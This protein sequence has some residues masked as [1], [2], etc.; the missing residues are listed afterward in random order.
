MMCR[1]NNNILPA[2]LMTFTMSTTGFD[3]CP[4]IDRWY[5]Q[6]IKQLSFGLT[7]VTLEQ[8]IKS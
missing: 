5:M 8:S 7:M 2:M 6:F 1:H 3:D 4:L